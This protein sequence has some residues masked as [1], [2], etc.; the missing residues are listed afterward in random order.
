MTSQLR[1]VLIALVGV[2]ALLSPGG[3][4]TPDGTMVYSRI[5]NWQ[6][7][8]QHWDAYT[9]DLKKNTL[10]VLDK[11]L[12]DGVITEYGV[13][14]ATVHTAEGYTHTTWFSS[15]TLAD[16]EKGLAALVAADAKLPAAERKRVDTDFAGTKHSDV[17]ARTRVVR[18]RTTKMTSGYLQV[19]LDQIQ[20]GQG[21][22]FNAYL[23][24]TARPII[25][26]LFTSG[27]VTSF[28]VDT[29]FIHTND[30]N[31]RVRWVV[32]PDA[33]GLDKVA[34]AAMAAN[35][36]Q[37]PA[38]RDELTKILVPGA[39]RDELWQITAFASKY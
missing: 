20:P 29:E 4:Q 6:I 37:S 39:H 21:Q 36:T 31:I 23:E 27:A 24:K 30:P 28:G 26:P 9:E 18:G 35:R 19:A 32:L 14:S 38:D 3:A 34:D 7:A 25:E 33:A 12:A 13:A 1:R 2:V 10:P 15:R 16:L 22:A 17:L 5:A 8:R 11:L